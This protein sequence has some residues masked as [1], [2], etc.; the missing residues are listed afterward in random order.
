MVRSKTF[1]LLLLSLLMAAQALADPL[2]PVSVEL[3]AFVVTEVRHQDG[4]VAEEFTEAAAVLPG[5][6]IEYRLS[7]RNGSEPLLGGLV[8]L[9]GPVPEQTRYLADSATATG[10]DV[11]LEASLDGETFAEP[12][13]FVVEADAEGREVEVE[14]DPAHY[15]ALRWV[16]LRPLQPDEEIV[17]RYRVVVL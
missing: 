6:V 2:D 14:A 11:R 16:I 1:R 5:Q 7:V 4:S 9:I 12:P 13:L 3:T 8:T 17:L 15:R 10:T